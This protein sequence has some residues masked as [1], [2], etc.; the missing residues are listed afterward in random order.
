MQQSSFHMFYMFY[1]ICS[2]QL[3]DRYYFCFLHLIDDKLKQ[4]KIKWHVHL[5]IG[6]SSGSRYWS[7]EPCFK[8]LL[9]AAPCSEMSPMD[10]PPDLFPMGCSNKRTSFSFPPHGFHSLPMVTS[11]SHNDSFPVAKLLSILHAKKYLY[12]YYY[13]LS[14]PLVTTVICSWGRQRRRFQFASL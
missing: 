2:L 11:S 5:L 4:R 13:H 12:L 1:T 8:P 6:T 3:C 7:P 10:P 9:Y 14:V